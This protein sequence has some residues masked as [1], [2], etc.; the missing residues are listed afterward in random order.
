MT[1]ESEQ[2]TPLIQQDLYFGQEIPNAGEV[3]EEAFQ[4]FV[5]RVITPLF[6]SGL[7]I[8]DAT[9]QTI[10][11]TKQ[12]FDEDTK[13]VTL[14]TED[15]LENDFNTAK[16]AAIYNRQFQGATVSQV[17]NK[18]ELKVGFGVGENLIENDLT[19][20]FI[21]VDLFFGR[22]I[23]GVG[24]VSEE[25]FQAFLDSQ[26]TPRFS[27]G[28]TVFDADGQFQ[29]DT[30]QV[31]KES[32][33]VV[34]LILEDTE[35]NEA[36]IDDIVANYIQQFQ[37]QSVLQAV[38]EDITVSFNTADD[39]IQNDPMPEPIQV[40][41]FFGRDIAGVGEVSQE[42]FQGFLD[43]QVTPR[44]PQFTVFDANGQFQDSAG[45]VIQER[46][47]IVSFILDDTETNEIAID[48][49]IGEY[50]EQFQQQ[51]VLAVVDE[52]IT[53]APDFEFGCCNTIAETSY[54]N[55]F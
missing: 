10:S 28:L 12:I 50:S 2:Q 24:E 45:D 34:S 30:G 7:T 29:D 37:Q 41:L 46:S 27:A 51:S 11:S 23:A 20:E 15:T 44:L 3:S 42:Q 39:L 18:D 36:A 38:N 33:K 32:S 26:V 6:P 1:L 21:Q 43:Q 22:N 4:L 48:Q 5:D 53:A 54:A 49:I 14:F 9:G 55:L 40:D 16:I 31:V 52:D 17:T 35:T 25:V 8:F 13:V 47:K 19:P